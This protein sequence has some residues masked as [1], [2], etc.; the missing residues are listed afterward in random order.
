MRKTNRNILSLL[1]EKAIARAAKYCNMS[2]TIQ[3]IRNESNYC[4]VVGELST[5][6]NKQKRPNA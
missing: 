1:V 3:H 2:R 6:K 5:P 4:E